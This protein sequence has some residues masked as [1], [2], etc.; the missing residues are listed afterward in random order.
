M[1]KIGNPVTPEDIAAAMSKTRPAAYKLLYRTAL[2]GQIVSHKGKL[3]TLKDEIASSMSAVRH[4]REGITDLTIGGHTDTT[5]N[6]DTKDN[7]DIHPRN[8]FNF[9]DSGADVPRGT[10]PLGSRDRGTTP[11]GLEV[12]RE[13]CPTCGQRNW[14]LRVGN[15]WRCDT[16]SPAVVSIAGVSSAAQEET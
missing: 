5:D 12:P 14:T 2:D 4:V 8:S 9:A 11:L 7:A 15:Q 3:F 6:N 10:I 1:E 13:S 16:C